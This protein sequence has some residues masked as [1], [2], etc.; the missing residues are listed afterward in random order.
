MTTVNIGNTDDPF[1]RYKRPVSIIENRSGKTIISNL[2]N[3]AKALETKPSYILYYIQLEKSTTITPKLEIKIILTK[4][5]IEYLLNKFI[6]EYI[7][8]SLCKYPETIIKK[9][10]GKLYFSCKACGH[11]KNIP[12]NKFTKKIY[13]DYI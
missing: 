1:Y 10:G 8:C 12:E 5:E 9:T 6:N 7:L 11:A 4:L 3:I 13:K 2:E